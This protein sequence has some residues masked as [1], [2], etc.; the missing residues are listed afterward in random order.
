VSRRAFLAGGGALALSI[1]AACGGDDGDAGSADTTTA[2]TSGPITTSNALPPASTVADSTSTTAAGRTEATTET[3]T[4]GVATLQEANVDPQWATGGLIFPLMW[5]ISD[6]MYVQDQQGKFQPAL[7]TGFTLSEDKLTWTFKLREGVKMH[8][9]S[10][11]TAQDVK[12]SV[13]RVTTGPFADTYAHLGNFKSNVTGA[14]VVDDLTVEITTNKPYATLVVDMTPPIAT[15]Y[16][17]RVGEDEFKKNPVCTGPWK[18]V[19]QELNSNVKYDRHDDF[20]D[21]NRRPNWKK[22]VYS[23]VP[24]ESARVAGMKTGQLDMA[25]GLSASSAESFQGDANVK[26]TEIKQTGMAYCMMWDLNIE[27]S[28]SPL[29]DVRVRRALLMAIDRESI[30]KALYK[31]FAVVPNSAM[32]KIT[33][34]YNPDTEAVPYDPEGA[35]ALLAEAGFPSF[36]VNLSTYITSTVPDMPK[37]AETIVP[38]W[39]QIGV[40]AKLQQLEGATYL[41]QVRNKQVT[42]AGMIAGPTFFYIE[43]VRLTATSFFWSNAPYTT[44]VGDAKLDGFVDQLNVETDFDKRAAIGREAGDYLDEQ[45]FGL[46]IVVTSSLV[47]VGPNVAEFGF[48]D[49]NPYA[50]PTWYTLAK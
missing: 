6:F 46:P 19:S 26:I 24:D 18:F 3:L 11:F 5:A 13:D 22:L 41:P 48:I 34:G 12:T 16:Y 21:V 39:E 42:G 49:T 2:T 45:L 29:R 32:P 33:P 17:N 44:V 4:I 37:L 43:P 14:N 20:W 15:E 23:I 28:V 30:V 7:A 8:D 1:L 47:A 40:T 9:G 36:E 35:K 25:Y 50:G 31:G 27:G 10:A 38:F